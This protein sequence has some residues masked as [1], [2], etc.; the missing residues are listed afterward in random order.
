MKAAFLS[1]S[2][3]SPKGAAGPA[4]KSLPPGELLEKSKRAERIFNR[5]EVPQS[6]HRPQEPVQA[7]VIAPTRPHFEE[8]VQEPAAA[9]AH[10]LIQQEV[11]IQ[12]EA[13][14]QLRRDKL[15]RVRMSIR[16]SPEQHL[17]LK[18]IAAHTR[19]SAQTIMDEALSEY[20][21]NHGEELIPAA[22]ACIR[23]KLY[24]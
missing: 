4:S 18:L 5:S 22:C 10:D 12:K 15:G 2:L 13:T 19:K 21:N 17:Q 9:R 24:S 1:S 14:D 23:N 16:M 6:Q 8:P 3:I 11:M 20:V 7:S